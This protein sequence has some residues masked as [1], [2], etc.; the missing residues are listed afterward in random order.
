M[1]VLARAIENYGAPE[2]GCSDKGPEF[3]ARTVRAAWPTAAS[4][5]S[6]ST[7]ASPVGTA[8]SSPLT[9][10]SGASA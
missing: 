1:V 7:R 6:P 8:T 10:T 4:A 2:H 9:P 3:V 5:P